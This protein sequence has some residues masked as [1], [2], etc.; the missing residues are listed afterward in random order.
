MAY[1]LATL[2]LI[3]QYSAENG[4]DVSEYN[5]Q[6]V[7]LCI[8]MAADE[9][10]RITHQTKRMDPITLVVGATSLPALPTNFLPEFLISADLTLSG[11]LIKPG[12]SFTTREAVLAAQLCGS[13]CNPSTPPTSPPT[14]RPNLIGFT[15]TAN[16]ITDTTIDKAY[17]L[18]LFWY[19]PFTSWVAG[20]SPPSPNSFN[21]PDDSLRAI[22]IGASGYLQLSEKENAVAA[23]V[24]LDLFRADAQAFK[25]RDAGGRAPLIIERN[26]P[27]WMR[28]Q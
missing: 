24:R 20:G 14:G 16:A 8:Q 3:T 19:A 5:L 13:P 2:Q 6:W 26:P 12:V 1:N 9:W 17:T 25:A 7:D 18:N 11:Q 4:K 28:G 27:D 21:L 22:A 10:I 15:D 23:K